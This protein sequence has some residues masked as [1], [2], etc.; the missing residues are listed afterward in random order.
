[1]NE[2]PQKEQSISELFV[3]S[4]VSLDSGFKINLIDFIS[5]DVAAYDRRVT[6]EHLND[7]FLFLLSSKGLIWDQLHPS[8]QS[9]V[10]D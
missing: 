2:A 9:F 8:K 5:I 4:S 10:C 1:M 3:Y 6:G 7:L